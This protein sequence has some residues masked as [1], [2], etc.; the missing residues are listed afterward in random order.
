M[1]NFKTCLTA[2]SPALP[3][4]WSCNDTSWLPY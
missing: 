4:I 3:R 2:C 1:A